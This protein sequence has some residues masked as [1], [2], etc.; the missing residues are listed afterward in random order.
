MEH[1]EFPKHIVL[2]YLRVEYLHGTLQGRSVKHLK[3]FGSLVK[4]RPSCDTI[5]LQYVA[6]RI[7]QFYFDYDIPTSDRNM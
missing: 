3:G 4:K 2:L 1:F 6:H 7:L 5:I